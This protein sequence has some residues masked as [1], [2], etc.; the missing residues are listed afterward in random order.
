MWVKVTPEERWH[1]VPSMM[2][3][4]NGWVSTRC[5]YAVSANAPL[6][7][8]TGDRPPMDEQITCRWCVIQR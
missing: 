3:D 7:Q 8:A 1:F 6:F 4:L 5:G 2:P